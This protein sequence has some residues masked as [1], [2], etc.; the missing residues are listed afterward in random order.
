MSELRAGASNA[1]NVCMGVTGK[2]KVFII[3]DRARREIGEALAAECDLVGTEN[4]VAVL[5]DY[6]SRPLLEYPTELHDLLAAFRPTVTFLALTAGEGE[7]AWRRPFMNHVIYEMKA[8]HGHMIGIDER[9]MREGM[10]ADYAEI[11][12]L[13]MQVN[14]IVKEAR[15]VEV[16]APSGTDMRATLDPSRLRWHPCPGIYLEPGTWGNLPEGET[17]TS[18]ASIDGIIGAEVLGDHLSEKYGV[19]AQP[20]TL[21]VENGRV[22]RVDAADDE[23]QRDLDIYLAQHEN[24]NRAGEFAIG[25]NVALKGLSGNLLQD[26]KLPGV[27]VAFGYPYPEETGA[28]WTCPSHIDVVATRSTIKVDGQYLM[29]DGKFVF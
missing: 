26:E 4:R 22:R 2:D 15:L 12:R 17:Y 10:S 3:T 20:V 21:E 6:G 23:I 13:T 16:Q 24:S 27:H 1:V 5:E 9:C 25:T 7:L 11:E 14:E 28:N 18:P 19:L 8:R 29:R